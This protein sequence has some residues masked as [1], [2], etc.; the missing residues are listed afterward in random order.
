MLFTETRLKG[1]F[2][3]EPER[4]EDERGFFARTWCRQEFQAHG[5]NPK[6][7]QCSISFNRKSG[8][9]R[10]MHYQAAP[11]AEAKLI[12]CTMGAIYD[13]ALDLRPGSAT[14]K[15]WTAVDLTAEN[16]KMLY[17]SEGIA[18]GFQ[19]LAD[20]TEV[21]YQISEHYSL[22]AARGVRWNDPAF[23]IRWPLPIVMI[24]KRDQTY[25]S[26]ESQA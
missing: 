21:H 13:V 22:E 19:T 11:H 15:Q 7:V 3:I 4:L 5:L 18:H 1:V 17:I 25:L 26:W 12:R 8:T 10:G 6:L 14:F 20:D 16:R 24:S 23:G 2:I 9:L